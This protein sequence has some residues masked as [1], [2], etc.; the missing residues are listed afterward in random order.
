[1]TMEKFFELVQALDNDSYSYAMDADKNEIYL[2]ENG[3]YPSS[4][5]PDELIDLLATAKSS[6]EVYSEEDSGT[7]MN[8]YVFD[9]FVVYEV[10]YEAVY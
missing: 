8:K 4:D 5:L 9:N 7:F 3:L 2:E 1:M 10:V 6:Y